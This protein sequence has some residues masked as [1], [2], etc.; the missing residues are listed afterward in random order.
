MSKEINRR[1]FLK[2]MGGAALG[3]AVGGCKPKL[4]ET[5]QN[6]IS[7][8]T[9]ELIA[10]TGSIPTETVTP[11]PVRLAQ[12]PKP[13]N[14]VV[15]ENTITEKGFKLAGIPETIRSG[16]QV[17]IAEN[18]FANTI[19]LGT[20]SWLAEP[21]VILVG[22]D[23]DNKII[24]ESGGHIEYLNP[25]NQQVFEGPEA[26][27]NIPEG[28]FMIASGASM[29]IALPEN[30]SI[31]LEGQEG[32]NWFA[33]VRGLFA[34]SKQDSDR[35]ITAHFT[36]YVPGHTLSMRYPKGA[37]ISEEHFEQ[38][39]DKAH[40]GNTNCGAEGC[41]RVSVFFLDLNTEACTIITR[42]Q[43]KR[44]QQLFSNW[45]K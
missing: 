25:T 45:Q 1:D 24:Q 10:T 15:A 27:F 11:T 2:M 23:F 36:D 29:T 20:E 4:P 13:E 40:Q 42:E 32:H 43:G 39:A 21:G 14:T 22:P 28:G 31:T 33:I 44:W 17:L 16:H 37:F 6:S 19:G 30:K 3:L 12:T 35:N 7:E 9:S 5:S 18:D 26:Y 8:P 41:S 38:I 34:D